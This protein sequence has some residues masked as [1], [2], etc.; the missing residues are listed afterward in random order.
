MHDI[1]ALKDWIVQ[2]ARLMVGIP[3]YRAYEEPGRGS[4]RTDR[5]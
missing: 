2:A 3:D 5:L 1:L 4:I